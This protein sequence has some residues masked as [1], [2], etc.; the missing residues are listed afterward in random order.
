MADPLTVIGG[1]ASTVQIIDI[2]TKAVAVLNTLRAQ[3]Q[4]SDIALISLTSQ[5]GA[6]S[7]A[8]SKIQEW[9][10]SAIEEVHHQLVMDLNTAINC[11]KMLAAKVYTEISDLQSGNGGKMLAT[12]KARFLFRRSG[13]GELQNMIDRQTATLTLLLTACNSKSLSKQQEILGASGVRKRMDIVQKDSESLHVLA[14]TSSFLSRNT[15][16][17]SRLS[18]LFDFDEQLFSSKPYKAM[19]RKTVKLSIRS[20]EKD[21]PGPEEVVTSVSSQG[22]AAKTTFVKQM[23]WMYASGF[24]TDERKVWQSTIYDDL[25]T[26]FGLLV[27]TRQ[28]LWKNTIQYDHEFSDQVD[29]VHSTLESEQEDKF[30][31]AFASVFRRLVRDFVEHLDRICSAAYTP[32][33][34]DIFQAR[35]RTTGIHK[36]R[37]SVPDHG[38]YHFYDVG[39]ERVERKKWINIFDQNSHVLLFVPMDSYDQVLYED[40]ATIRMQEALALFGSLANS[41]NWWTQSKIFLCFTKYDLFEKKISAGSSLLSDYFPEYDGPPTDVLA[42]RK[43]L[44][45]RFTNLLEQRSE[46]DVFYFNATNTEEVRGVVETILGNGYPRSGYYCFDKRTDSLSLNMNMK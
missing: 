39:G 16:R 26:V 21:G 33:S 14:D 17:S 27:K 31:F 41:T 45:D 35:A 11:C 30:P 36:Y 34:E 32:T 46:L 22:E 3:W 9:M 6:L 10:E 37:F 1:V 24:S 44:T 40:E 43:Y 4:S 38:I 18:M 42:A 29:L 13:V 5:L 19:I 23:Q 12:A 2:L 8:L 15:E 20:P 25:V 28:E 7:A